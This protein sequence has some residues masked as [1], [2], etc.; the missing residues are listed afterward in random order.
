[1]IS[2]I[3]ARTCHI[4]ARVF[5]RWRKPDSKLQPSVNTVYDLMISAYLKHRFLCEQIFFSLG[6]CFEEQA[7]NRYGV[8]WI[9]R[10]GWDPNGCVF[11]PNKSYLFSHVSFTLGQA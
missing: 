6:L 3:V 11:I 2:L 9:A 8:W 5:I 4:H 1:M 10:F 7:L